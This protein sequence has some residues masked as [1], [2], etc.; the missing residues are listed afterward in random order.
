[1]IGE[2]DL[3]PK[4]REVV[5]AQ[6]EVV[7]VL[8]GAGSGKT[9]TALWAARAELLRSGESSRR[10]AFLTFS[11]TAVDQISSR[12]AMALADMGNHV[13][14]STFHAMA[15]RLLR[16]FGRYAGIGTEIPELQSPAQIKLQGPSDNLLAYDD[17]M[18][19]A[20]RVL[21]S[22]RVRGLLGKR[23]PLVICDEFQDTSDE[24]W[25]FLKLLNRNSRLVLLADPNQMIYTFVRG[26]SE[27]RLREASDLANRIVE[28]EEVSHRDPTGAIPALALAVMRRQFESEAVLDAIASGRL[29]VRTD[30]ADDALIE[31]I[32]EELSDSY[33]K[34]CSRLRNIRSFERG[35]RV[36]GAP[37]GSRGNRTRSHRS[38]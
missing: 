4:Q 2:S 32:K 12:S 27:E 21:E 19:M 38:S 30:I 1:M 18:P 3:S 5:E 9:T 29:R 35:G 36:V 11:R 23:W 37:F 13:E 14:V 34:W 20:L 25:E 8:G 31:V 6:E 33:R 16:A 10:V 28:L 26:V 22:E 15:Y 7:L 24:Q 17:L